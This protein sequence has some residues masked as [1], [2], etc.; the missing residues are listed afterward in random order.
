MIKLVFKELNKLKENS[1][2]IKQLHQSKEQLK[3]HIALA[4]ENKVNLMLALG[5]SLLYFDKIDTNQ[6]IFDSIDKITSSDLLDLSNMVFQEDQ[7]S[8]LIYN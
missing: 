6:E 8:M 1:L 3:G 7:L 5:K 4:Q 2:G